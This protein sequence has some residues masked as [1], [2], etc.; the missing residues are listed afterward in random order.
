MRMYPACRPLIAWLFE[1]LKIEMICS[2]YSG[3]SA[4]MEVC[5]AGA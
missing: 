5:V 4:A 2:A 1:K 3:A